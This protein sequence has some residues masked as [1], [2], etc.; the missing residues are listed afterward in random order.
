MRVRPTREAR[1][2]YVWA[3]R[4]SFFIGRLFRQARDREDGTT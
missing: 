4:T 1:T 3:P 2:P